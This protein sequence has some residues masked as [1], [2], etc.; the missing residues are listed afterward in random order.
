[1]RGLPGS[2]TPDKGAAKGGSAEN[3][4]DELALLIDRLYECPVC[5]TK[6]SIKEVKAGK[7]SSDGLD[8]DLRTRY[9]N[10]DVNKYKVIE[11][12][13]CGYADMLKYYGRLSKRE[14]DALKQNNIGRNRSELSEDYVRSYT[15]AYGHYK[16][17]LRC[18]LVRG[19]KSS[20]R[21]YTALYSAWLL[22]GWRESMERSG[23]S[24]DG[25]EMSKDEER[26]LIKY[27][28]KNL[29]DAEMNEDFPINDMNEPV[30]D[31]LM[32]ALSY[33]QG[34]L[35][36][37]GKYVMRALQNK[38]LKGVVRPMAEDLRDMIKND[39]KKMKS[40]D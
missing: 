37:A 21:A 26:K 40:Q 28:L 18:N 38:G 1:M 9:K 30:F 8:M 29:K 34:D 2:P 22:R 16:A 35:D 23:N 32:A 39:R 25:L 14:F 36:D 7:A 27:A 3:D 10:I 20:K 5:T 15:D 11:C 4:M 6:F 13:V 24:T 19:A 33:E 12:P 31:Y 17:A